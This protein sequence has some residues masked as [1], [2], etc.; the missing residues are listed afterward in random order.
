MTFAEFIIRKKFVA[1]FIRDH[2]IGIARDYSLINLIKPYLKKNQ[3]ILD[4]GAG[5]CRITQMLQKKGYMV[6]PIDIQD[7]SIIDDIKPIIYDGEKLPFKNNSCD[8][9]LL[10][11]VLHHTPNPE[12][13]LREAKR[14][15]RNIVIIEDIYENTAHKYLTYFMDSIMN[16]E[17][18]GHPHSNKDD[19][20]WK[21]LFNKLNLKLKSKN[22]RK[23]WGVFSIAT[24]YLEK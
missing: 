5:L 4:I 13:I 7:L 6:T 14:V 23:V 12:A 18:F 1:N 17:F 24:Y 20:G 22:Y 15:S 21:E 11:T 19:K 8:V 2:K 10:L 9:A 3:Q 16:L